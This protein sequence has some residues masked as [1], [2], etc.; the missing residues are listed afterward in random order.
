MTSIRKGYLGLALQSLRASRMRSF[1][2]MLGIV[3]G[4]MSVIVI[5]GV[6]EGVKDQIAD[7]SARYGKDVLIVRPDTGSGLGGS[8][9][10]VATSL[11]EPADAETLR[12]SPSVQQVVP[13]STLRGAIKADKSVQ[14]P[15][16]IA[17]SPELASLVHQKMEFGG[18]FTAS[19]GERVAVLGKTVAAQLFADVAPLGQ[20]LTF[21]GQQFTV[22]GVFSSFTAAPFSLEANY[23]E[24][25][26]I[27]YAAA[28]SLLGSPPR[29]NQLFVQAK[30]GVSTQVLATE[31]QKTISD[32][33]GGTD[34]VAVLSPGSKR[35][36]VEPTLQ[37][38]TL[39]TVCMAIVALVV[40]GAGIMNMM[41]VSVTERIHEIGLRKAIGATNKQILRQFMTEAF[42]LCIVGAVVGV[43]ASLAAIGLLRMYTSLSPAIV[44]P[45]VVAAPLIALATGVLFGAIP[46]IKAARMDPI[47]ALR[48]E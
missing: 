10:G 11:L 7:Q 17:T 44:W 20:Q 2:T 28:Q 16:V 34:D 13:L 42:A 30:P 35:G 4:V 37:L 1:M 38:L 27:P 9:T 14:S 45:V 3:I 15:L 22:A 39:M 41:L 18:F 29:M 47:E 46:A 19:D 8:F 36:G 48:H 5:V 23:N 31:L 21:R 24:A 12:R 25:V 40:G 33:H 6:G 32:S 43:V 26:F